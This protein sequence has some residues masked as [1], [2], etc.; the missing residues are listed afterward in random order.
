[1][2][3]DVDSHLH[4]PFE[5][6]TP[7]PRGALSVSELTARLK[8]L[9]ERGFGSLAVE[10][11]ISNC[12]Q[13]SSGHLYFT[14]KDDYAQLR[15]VMFR[16]TARQLK[17]RPAD[18]MHVVARGRLSVYETKGEYQ[19]VC[20][21]LEPHGLGALQLAFEQ[22]KKR[23]QADGLFDAARKRPLPPLRRAT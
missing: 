16:T 5:D 17:F 14:L 6:E 7:V 20:D 10:G 23:L 1:V 15:A 8:Q 2:P 4:L 18:G 21:A 3:A 11:E 13:W 12:R 9:V 19:M 22:L